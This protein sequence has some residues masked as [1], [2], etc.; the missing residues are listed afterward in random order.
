MTPCPARAELL[1]LLADRLPAEQER[2]V[3]AHLETC[4][5]CQAAL[6]ELTASCAPDHRTGDGEP[7]REPLSQTGSFWRELKAAVPVRDSTLRP[8]SADSLAGEAK[9]SAAA[10]PLPARLGR[11]ELLEEI[12]R[13]GMG[14][15]LRGHD[16]DL[17]R[18]LAVKILLPDH[19]DDPGVVS[20]FT[21]EAQI[22][23]QLQHPGIVPVYEV[24]RSDDR[25][26]YFTMKLVRGRTLAEL[27]RQRA[28]P[29]QDLPRFLQVFEQVC[30]TL[31]YAHSRG[32]IHR[33][34]KPANVMVGAFGEVQ[35]MDWGL[36]KRLQ[37]PEARTHGAAQTGGE[38]GQRATKPGAVM[39]TPAYLAPEQARGENDRLDERCDVF[40]LGG[41][42]CE[43]LT[44]RPPYDGTDAEVLGKALR[45]ELG[46]AL[47]RLDGCGADPDLIRLARS[48]LATRAEARPRDGGVLAAELCAYR[49]SV[50]ARLRQAELA[51]ARADVERKRRRLALGLAASVLLTVLVAGGGWLWVV[52]ERAEGERQA[53]EPR[54]KQTHEAEGALAQALSLRG[55]A[56]EEG[57]TGPWAEARAQARRAETLLERLP[58]RPDLSRRGR[59]LLRELDDEEADRRLLARLEEI[60][61]FKTVFLSQELVFDASQAV[62]EY[63]KALRDYG[64]AVGELPRQ[65]GARVR[66]RPRDVRA[67]VVAALDD[68][69]CLLHC[70]EGEKA[71]WLAAV[72]AEADPDPWRKRLR[73]ARH[74]WDRAEL[75]R[76]ADDPALAGQPAHTMLMLAQGLRA[77]GAEQK[78][79]AL[80][81]RAQALHPGDFWINCLLGWQLWQEPGQLADVVRFLT[82]A[83]ALKPD[84]PGSSPC[85]ASSWGRR[86]TW[87]GRL[88]S[89][90]GPLR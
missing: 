50:E 67:R 11:Y 29:R 47:A 58:G 82:A 10:A 88:P 85:W 48:C 90:G 75:E 24:G 27:L 8:G 44:G 78:A 43:I 15:V 21:E 7:P 13:G 9:G 72:L 17:G 2:P 38:L 83:A 23:G 26:L 76:L 84:S 19:Q 61:L 69:L 46:E 6:E 41:I 68:W 86:G 81:R 20:R 64:V 60:R 1:D 40:G 18:D 5:A 33:D 3:M 16:S 66:Q 53:H 25:L 12:G 30:Q 49:E 55:Q 62:P 45:A 59:A 74:R 56:R 52:Q 80:L 32:V 28:D 42:L 71:E 36:A 14:C 4:P 57:P 35:V 37:T 22:G 65:A 87:R 73:V 54:A 51:Q 77:C 34:L 79:L 39:G 63:E 70:S 89:F 31:A